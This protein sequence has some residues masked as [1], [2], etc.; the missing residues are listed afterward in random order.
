MR[1]TLL[2]GFAD[3]MHLFIKSWIFHNSWHSFG[4]R[5]CDIFLISRNELL[6]HFFSIVISCK[7]RKTLLWG[8]AGPMHLFIKCSIFYNF[9]PNSVPTFWDIFS[10]SEMLLWITS[11][12]HRNILQ[13]R[14]KTALRGFADPMHLFIKYS[15]FHNFW[16]NFGPTF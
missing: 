13:K 11:L 10:I 7:K 9:W 2:W 6:N 15:I 12:R 16:P 3:P 4:A 1:K 14:E 8:F 5:V